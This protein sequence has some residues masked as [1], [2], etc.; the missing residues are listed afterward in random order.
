MEALDPFVLGETLF[1]F[2]MLTRLVFDFFFFITR[3][4]AKPSGVLR[5]SSDWDDLI[6]GKNQSAKKSVG[7]PTKAQNFPGTKINP[8]INPI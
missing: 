3:Q 4:Q 8:S 2:T 7:L 1:V 5:I 6:G